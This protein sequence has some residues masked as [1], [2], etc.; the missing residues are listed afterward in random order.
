MQSAFDHNIHIDS[1][2][3]PK[4][5][6]LSLNMSI[7]DAYLLNNSKPSKKKYY[8]ST[9]VSYK[10]GYVQEIDYQ[11]LPEI[12]PL[13]I[14]Q[15]F[16]KESKINRGI[17][18]KTNLTSKSIFDS[19]YSKCFCTICKKV[20]KFL[21][22]V[23]GYGNCKNKEC[24]KIFSDKQKQLTCLKKY[25]RISTFD[26]EKSKSTKK[27]R[28]GNANYNNREKS[29]ITCIVKYGFSNPG[30]NEDIKAK[31]KKT[32]Y[33]K[34]GVSTPLK[35]GMC[36]EKSKQT[37]KENKENDMAYMAKIQ[38]KRKNT[39]IDKYGVEHQSN[40][41][42]VQSKRN[43]TL[44]KEYGYISTSNTD[45]NYAIDINEN[46][47]RKYIKDGIFDNKS[48][49]VYHNVSAGFVNKK[50][51][52]YKIQEPNIFTAEYEVSTY[53]S[54]STNNTR[55]IISPYELDIYSE[56]HKFAV[57][58]NGLMFHSS[59]ISS[60]SMFNTPYKDKNYHLM[61]TNLCEEKGIQL[62]H[63]FEN[64]WLNPVKKEIWISMLNG[65]QNKH[66]KLG[67]RKCTIKEVQGREAKVFLEE[68]HLQGSVPASTRVALIYDNEIVSLM[69]F[70]KARISK[71][72]DKELY[73]FCTKKNLTVQGAGSR[74]LKYFEDAYKPKSLV[75][76]ANR[77]WSEGNLYDK[78]NFTFSHDSTPNMFWFKSASMKIES[79]Q[80]YQK[81]KLKDIPGFVFNPDIT[82][83]ANMFL[84]DYRVIYDSGNK[85]YIKEYKL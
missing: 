25:G 77:R 55:N 45:I 31:I 28:Y 33:K 60:Y 41:I 16:I 83:K 72:Y 74:L 14:A 11:N 40:S 79:R 49:M 69:T 4:L 84:N 34:Y 71:K 30:Q 26:I 35:S 66:T 59:G 67:A 18:R 15:H 70:G 7:E 53:I 42:I 81:H 56:N 85:V 36:I 1:L 54:N 5:S 43:E 63:I 21:S 58:Y 38:E 76:Y 22:Y 48:V 2:G 80:T 75:S 47:W 39:C 61:K 27:E 20:P 52:I 13:R 46:S 64:E 82:A 65:K 8:I 19:I 17:L 62:F 24:T 32:N 78:L 51:I 12:I 6:F 3:R 37:K 50:K 44:K 73:R 9:F 57:E 23:K 10:R 29:E 68:N